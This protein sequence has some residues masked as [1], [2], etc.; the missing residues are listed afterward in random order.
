[1][2]FKGRGSAP[3]DLPL[4]AAAAGTAGSLAATAVLVARSA[5]ASERANPPAGRFV[6]VN[7]VKLHY[8]ERGAG[9]PVVLLH[10]NALSAADWAV[11]GVL[12]RLA[13]DHRVIAFDRPGFGYSQRPKN[14][15]WTP[16]KQAK[17]IHGALAQIGVTRPV[18]VA[19]SW[20]TL[21]A[22]ALALDHPEDVERLVLLS[23]Y[24]FPSA[25]VDGALQA[26][27]LTPLLGDILR[28]T[29]LPVAGRLTAPLTKHQLFSPAPV[30]ERFAQFP[31]SMSLRPS[32]LRAAAEE[33]VL[34]VPA[35][36]ELQ[37]RYGELDMPIAII[38]GSGDRVVDPSTQSNRLAQMVRKEDAQLVEGAGHMVHYFAPDR[39]TAAVRREEPLKQAV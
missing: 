5:R 37:K 39:V 32:Q 20:G 36:A 27:S 33:G 16:E 1:M 14:I 25:R 2:K 23:G 34:M 10:G 15:A 38:A 6:T 30:P 24:Y 4:I 7:G 22:L 12:D 13:A 9:P 17:L 26:P 28:Y 11:S 3:L 29:I 19:H 8:L 21:V 35:A 31:F 18:V